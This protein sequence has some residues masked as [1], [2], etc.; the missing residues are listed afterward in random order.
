M[1]DAEALVRS[2]EAL[3]DHLGVLCVGVVDAQE[4]R[5]GGADTQAAEAE[6]RRPGE[7]AQ[8]Q[9]RG[10]F[11]SVLLL[12]PRGPAPPPPPRVGGSTRLPHRRSRE[13]TRCHTPGRMPER[14]RLPLVPQP[15]LRHS[16]NRRASTS[17]F[18]RGA[19]ANPRA[20]PP[21]LA[22]PPR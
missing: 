17:L 16:T 22:P 13:E 3:D 4:A 6:E 12:T 20:G 21:C 18:K 1:F 11:I 7:V 19:S 2:R 9:H 5:A 15:A 8:D 10:D 14:G